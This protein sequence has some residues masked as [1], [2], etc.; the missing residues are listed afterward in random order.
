[1]TARERAVEAVRVLEKLS[2]E[3]IEDWIEHVIS[4]AV[5]EE[6]EAC[7]RVADEYIKP[8]PERSSQTVSYR[9]ILLAENATA[10]LIAADIRERA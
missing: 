9:D 6:R 8:V 5:L 1:M 7:A 4:E 10:E 3:Q 2:G